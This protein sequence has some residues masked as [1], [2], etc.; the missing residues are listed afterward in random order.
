MEPILTPLRS[1]RRTCHFHT[2]CVPGCATSRAITLPHAV[3]PAPASAR[4]LEVSGTI[5]TPSAVPILHRYDRLDE[6][7]ISVLLAGLVA[8]RHVE[9]MFTY[10]SFWQRD[11]TSRK[12]IGNAG[13]TSPRRSRG[14]HFLFM[15]RCVKLFLSSL[16]FFLLFSF[17]ILS[18]ATKLITFHSLFACV[19]SICARP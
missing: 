2:C 18:L 4:K 8:P 16:S 3:L 19:C 14:Q 11:H 12:P 6:P 10:Y 9:Q 5:S 7:V 15:T 13:H 1:D 17:T